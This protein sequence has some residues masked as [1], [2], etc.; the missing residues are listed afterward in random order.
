MIIKMLLRNKK[1]IELVSLEL[2]LIYDECSELKARIQLE[3]EILIQKSKKKM[4]F[5]QIRMKKHYQN[6]IEQIKQANEN[7]IY[8]IDQYQIKKEKL[9]T[10]LLFN[11]SI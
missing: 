11:I 6:K 7:L 3:S 5:I 8:K 10:S 4:M 2:D 9:L 1:V